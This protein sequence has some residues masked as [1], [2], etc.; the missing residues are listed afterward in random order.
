V[1]H[2]EN[3]QKVMAPFQGT[4]DKLGGKL[5]PT[6]PRKN[7][8]STA[9]AR[10]WLMLKRKSELQATPAANDL[11]LDLAASKLQWPSTSTLLVYDSPT[12]TLDAEMWA[13][14]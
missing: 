7:P 6:L 4:D 14:P 13:T 2:I 8:S 1:D 11:R 9:L 3:Y 5:W 12:Y 10:R